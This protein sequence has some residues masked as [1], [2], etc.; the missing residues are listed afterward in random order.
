[1]NKALGK[2]QQSALVLSIQYSVL[3]PQY[4]E[5]WLDLGLPTMLV[6]REILHFA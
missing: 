2:G 1:M 6:S 3:G 4:S 5:V